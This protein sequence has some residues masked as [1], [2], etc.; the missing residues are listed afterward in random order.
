MEPIGKYRATRVSACRIKPPLLKLHLPDLQRRGS[1]IAVFEAAIKEG[2]GE[3]IE[4]VLLDGLLH[5][6]GAEGGG[7]EVAGGVV[8]GE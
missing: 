4:K 3:R 2:E 7:G 8:G 1:V 5:R 6:A